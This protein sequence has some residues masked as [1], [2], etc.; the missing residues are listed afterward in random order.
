MANPISTLLGQIGDDTSSLKPFLRT[1]GAFPPIVAP[2]DSAGALGRIADPNDSSKSLAS[3]PG[4]TSANILGTIG[5]PPSPDVVSNPRMDSS[6]AD[7]FTQRMGDLNADI[8]RRENPIA[9]TTAL[10]K[11]G[12]VAANIGNV[13]GNIFAP[14]EMAQFD[15]TQLGNKRV[16]ARDKADLTQ[17]SDLQTA[18]EQRKGIE[19]TTAYTTARPAIEQAK[20]LQKLTSTLAPKGIKA[21]MNPD[22]TIDTE[23]D[24][25]SQAYKDRVALDSYRGALQERAQVQADNQANHYVPGTPQYEE[26]QRKLSQIDTR[27]HG[28][29]MSLG[30][31]AQSVNQGQQRI[32]LDT[33]KTYNPEPTA[34]ERTKGDLASSAVDRIAEMKSIVAKHPEYFGPVAGR[35]Q[36]AQAW[37]GSSDPDAVTYNTAA[38]YLADHSAGV[39]GGRGQYIMQALHGLT[40]PKYTPEGLNAALDEAGRA[41][42]GFVAAGATH[43]KGQLG[44]AAASA[45]PQGIYARD[46]QGNLHTAPAG[47][48]LPKG[49]KEGK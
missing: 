36:N 30:L 41:A 20:V 40:D 43:A 18:D 24:T 32:N 39:F 19:A 14:A 29:L 33:D 2:P 38:Q 5:I 44:H 35:A 46:P 45:Q 4:A 42:Q 15:N 26:N 8:Y 17:E 47:T 10:G 7:P 22:G 27:L 6:A 49:W 9:P 1:P 34:T 28:M 37:L 3:M 13:L 16:I 21:T 31:R 11:I 25:D 12:H 23:D 48:A